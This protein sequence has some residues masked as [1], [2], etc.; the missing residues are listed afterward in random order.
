MVMGAD[1]P[2]VTGADWANA[3]RSW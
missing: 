2:M 3:V 1:W